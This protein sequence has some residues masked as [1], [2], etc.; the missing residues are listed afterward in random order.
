MAGVQTNLDLLRTIAAHPA[1]AA[2][3]L[4]T[5]FISRHEAALLPART[6]APDLALAAA[7]MHVLQDHAA[8]AIRL[9]GADRFSP[10]TLATAWRMNGDGYQDLLLQDGETVHHIR[11][12]PT[13]GGAML[14]LPGGPQRAQAAKGWLMLDGVRHR[15]NVVHSQDRLT[16]VLDGVNWPLTLIDPLAPVGGETAGGD[17][18]MAPMPGRVIQVLTEAGA[19]VQRGD[20]L[21]VLEAMKVQM[22]LTAPRDGVIAAVRAAPGDLVD[23]G[24]ELVSYAPA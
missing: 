17:R 6:Q 24:A 11:A 3:E 21:L 1:F 2:A 13:H 16:A 22:R 9:A 14:D 8:Q 7:A 5:G 15:V 12:H 20:V 18:V 19:T 4:D 23:D 10:W